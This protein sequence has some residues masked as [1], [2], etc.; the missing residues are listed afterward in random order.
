[1]TVFPPHFEQNEMFQRYQQIENEDSSF[2]VI[3][4]YIDARMRYISKH[5]MPLYQGPFTKPLGMKLLNQ[6]F[7]EFTTFRHSDEVPS[8]EARRTL[9][10]GPASR[11]NGSIFYNCQYGN[12]EMD[13]QCKLCET[14]SKCSN[15][16]CID[17]PCPACDLQ[18][19]SH[20]ILP[21]RNFT[22]EHL[23]T[24][25]AGKKEESIICA[26]KKYPGVLKS[27]QF[28]KENLENHETY[29]KVF[30]LRCKFC[31]HDY[32]FIENCISNVELR[33]KQ[34]I[35]S[36]MD[37]DTCSECFILVRI[38]ERSTK[39]VLIV[40]QAINV[41]CVHSLLKMKNL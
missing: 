39:R 16:S 10:W 31:R 38:T 26:Y 29:H 11:K 32:R 5:G 7:E 37:D 24:I 15:K 18:C 17:S 35:L 3:K 41:R 28:C 2:G 1:M 25:V 30:H 33:N 6:T 19:I 27:C 22:E 40:K 4:E 9:V 23:F 8:C 13:C 12:C 34:R 36:K 21:M 14:P 20:V